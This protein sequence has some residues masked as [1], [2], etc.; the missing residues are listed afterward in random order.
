M[1]LY[2]A[3]TKTST[4]P[5]FLVVQSAHRVR[6]NV[7]AV[8]ESQDLPPYL[9][10]VLLVFFAT[11]RKSKIDGKLGASLSAGSGWR[12]IQVVAVK[13]AEFFRKRYRHYDESRIFG[14]VLHFTPTTT[15]AKN[16]LDFELKTALFTKRISSA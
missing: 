14:V 6:E 9:F 3:T 15:S 4:V 1:L 10:I 16:G 5:S 12:G 13:T 7:P 11:S 2:G 8:P